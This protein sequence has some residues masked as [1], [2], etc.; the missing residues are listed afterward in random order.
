MNL[1]Q[2]TIISEIRLI[3]Q[4]FPDPRLAVSPSN[5]LDQL[6]LV[7]SRLF[8]NNFE[9]KNFTCFGNVSE[10]KTWS[11]NAGYSL[12]FVTSAV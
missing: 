9:E 3:K 2:E 7:P 10:K 12:G 6:G 4:L 11:K 5:T 8:P 1:I